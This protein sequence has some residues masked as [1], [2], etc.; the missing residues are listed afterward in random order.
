MA[1]AQ[2]IVRSVKTDGFP[3]VGELIGRL[4]ASYKAIEA[5]IYRAEHDPRITDTGTYW[6]NG[7]YQTAHGLLVPRLLR[8]DARGDQAHERRR[9]DADPDRRPTSRARRASSP[10][11]TSPAPRW[12]APSASSS[13][14]SAGISPA[15][16]FGQRLAHYERF[17][18]GEP[19][20][21]ASFYSRSAD[22]SEGQ[23]L[24][25]ELARRGQAGARRAEGGVCRRL[26]G[27][28]ANDRLFRDAMGMF[29]SGV[30]IVTVGLPGGELHG[31]TANAVMSVSLDPPLIAVAIDNRAHTNEPRSAAS[32]TSR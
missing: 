18:I 1:T 7:D 30:T 9:A 14:S 22:I 3:N 28:D 8:D 19:M 29:A 11:R 12:A 20:F 17:Y 2:A 26:T 31:M 6:P 32:A 21:V 13:A 27:A 10:R 5:I 25:D 24:L 4:I 16:R 15:T 23:V